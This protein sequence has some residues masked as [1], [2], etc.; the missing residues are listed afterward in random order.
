MYAPNPQALQALRRSGIELV[1]DVPHRDLQ[2]L[3]I[4][5]PAAAKWVRDNVLNYYPDVKFRIIAVGIE[6]NPNRGQPLAHLAPFVLL[7]MSK[8][9]NAIASP[10]LK[11]EIKVLFRF[12][13]KKIHTNL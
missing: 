9:Y 11:D 6:V 8:I 3:T 1:L 12:F 2:H 13:Q 10:R 7:A 4:D 5:A